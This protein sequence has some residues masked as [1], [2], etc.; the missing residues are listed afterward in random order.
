MVY[1]VYDLLPLINSSLKSDVITKRLADVDDAILLTSVGNGRN[2]LHCAASFRDLEAV[3]ALLHRE[4][5][6]NNINAED[7]EGNTA[8]VLA[9]KAGSA[10]C[11]LYLFGH[12]ADPAVFTKEGV[13]FLHYI[14]VTGDADLLHRLS[15][16]IFIS[17]FVSLKTENGN[18]PL[19]LSAKHGTTAVLKLLIKFGSDAEEANNAG[20]VPLI[21]ACESTSYET[22]SFLLKLRSKPPNYHEIEKML[23]ILIDKCAKHSIIA[24]LS[25]SSPLVYL[26]E[27][28]EKIFNIDLSP[29][30]GEFVKSVISALVELM[31]KSNSIVI[32]LRNMMENKIATELS[33]IV[34]KNYND[35]G[36][37]YSSKLLRYI[38]WISTL[39]RFIEEGNLMSSV[40]DYVKKTKYSFPGFFTSLWKNPTKVKAMRTKSQVMVHKNRNCL[41]SVWNKLQ[42]KPNSPHIDLKTKIFLLNCF[43]LWSRD[44]VLEEKFISTI[45]LYKKD[46]E[47]ILKTEPF[48]LSELL[49]FLRNLSSIPDLEIFVTETIYTCPLENRVDMFYNAVSKACTN[50]TRNVQINVDR[51]RVYESSCEQV[52]GLRPDSLPSL[53]ATYRGEEGAGAGVRTEWLNEM[54]RD[55]FDPMT[56][57][58]ISHNDGITFQPSISD[59]NNIAKDQYYIAGKVV[60]LNLFYRNTMDVHFTKAFYK[61]ILGI[62]LSWRDL[63]S[64]QVKLMEQILNSDVETLDLYFCYDYRDILLGEVKTVDLIP[65]GHQIR[66][67]ESNKNRYVNLRSIYIMTVS[68][69]RQIQYFVKG[70]YEI[71]P[72]ELL[73]YF[74]YDELERLMCGLDKINSR[75]WEEHCSY[76]QCEVTKW[77]WEV[78]SDMSD[79]DKQK[80]LMFWTCFIRVPYGG[81][82]QLS[83]DDSSGLKIQVNMDEVDM[84]PTTSTCVKLL[85]LTSYS[86][87]SVLRAKLTIAIR[88]SFLGFGLP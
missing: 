23:S 88:N 32:D 43:Y 27:F 57:L 65:S 80:L 54:T 11:A 86:S 15:S 76:E 50:W 69:D 61:N 59:D 62:P 29:E 16:K 73:R 77:F 33:I 51:R 70:F 5:F 22:L 21:L 19:H 25:T 67:T 68:I 75:D 60:G 1:S 30:H 44:D 72:K 35:I 63:P 81:F 28:N 36:R 55:I 82:K 17:K 13:C 85:K 20:D 79:Q 52:K 8:F 39:Y 37:E 4:C 84:L 47:N 18:T 24:L 34:D 46:I 6:K 40:P 3:K 12:D 74:K 53:T 2:I 41:D 87:K 9:C 26:R 14:A 10:N 49:S 48:E 38:N 7:I 45:K 83:D 66:V 64:D 56:G 78:V 58:F 71:I 42:N 31:D